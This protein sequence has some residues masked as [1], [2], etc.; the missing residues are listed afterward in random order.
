MM[1]QHTLFTN[2]QEYYQNLIIE[3]ANAKKIISISFL[4]FV[5]GE[6]AEKISQVLIQKAKSGVCVRLIVDEIGEIW[7]DR[8]FVF[9]NIQLVHHLRKQGIQVEVFRPTPPLKINNRLHCKFI[10]IDESIAYIGGSNIA[11][12]YTHWI[13]ANLRMN[14]NF[15]NTFH[16]LY[17]FLYNYSKNG[18]RNSRLLN[19]SNLFAGTDRLFLTVPRQQYDV[20][21]AFLNLILDADTFIYIRTWSFLPD[22]EI[23]NALCRQAKNGVQV[24]IL[25]SHRT[26]FRPL[27]YANYIHVH[28]LIDAGANVYRYVGN[29]MHTKVAW[30][31]HH[32]ILFGSANLESHSLRHNFETCLQINASHLTLELAQTFYSDLTSSVQQT[33][34]SHLHRS[35]VRKAITHACNMAILWL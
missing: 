3:L 31:N 10:A 35:L 11:D 6:W 16:Q 30:N 14:G 7:D 12:F 23:L 1:N 4:S 9:Q 22:E 15:G 32:N 34:Q 29:Y 26:R 21:N 27:D 2:V 33:S 8:A 18:N 17:N 5:Y 13:D 19:F 28:K 25:F 24:N 20:H